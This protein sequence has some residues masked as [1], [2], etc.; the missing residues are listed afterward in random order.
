MSENNKLFYQK[1]KHSTKT[2]NKTIDTLRK[3]L[4]FPIVIQNIELVWG[5][6]MAK[7]HVAKSFSD[8]FNRLTNHN[9]NINE[10]KNYDGILTIDIIN[11]T[12]SSWYEI[13]KLTDTGLAKI[14]KT[15][16]DEV[17]QNLLND[18][19]AHDEDSTHLNLT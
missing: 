4:N 3:Q 12:G 14:K 15:N 1:S 8:F 13:K 9:V 5:H 10:I 6:P 18:I 2:F 17:N 16:F 19:Y 11:Q 7:F